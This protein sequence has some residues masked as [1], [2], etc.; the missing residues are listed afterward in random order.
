[1]VQ[2]QNLCAFFQFR[3]YFQTNEMPPHGSLCLFDGTPFGGII[4]FNG[5]LE[6]HIFQ[7]GLSDRLG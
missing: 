4:S 6:E 2:T 3:K 1:M 7:I 5:T